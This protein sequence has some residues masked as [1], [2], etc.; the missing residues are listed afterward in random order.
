MKVLVTGGAGFIGSHTVVALYEAG[1]EPIIVDDFSNSDPQIIEGITAIIG[2]KPTVYQENCHSMDVLKSIFEKEQIEGVIHFAAFKA[3]GESMQKPLE[4]YD[5]NLGSLIVLLKCMLECGVKNLIFSSSCTVYGEPDA[6]PVTEQ[7]PVKPANS[8]YGNTQQIGEEIL[9][10]TVRSL[11][12]QSLKVLSLRYFNPVGAHPSA[13]IGELPRGVPNNLV[14]F[15][16]QAAAGIRGALTIFGDDYPTP[17]GTCIRDYIHVM[18]LA[19][20]HVAGFR[21]LMSHESPAIY[22]VV[23]VGT[24]SG[25]SVLELLQSFERINGL[26]V[27][28]KIGP[29]REGDVVAVYA[30]A[31]KAEKMLCW[32]ALRS[33]EDGLRDAWNWQK[34]TSKPE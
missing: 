14:P 1:F 9:S 29:R 4:Y 10:D 30:D 19:E 16:T 12:H 7:T 21:Y 28:Y 23:N 8:V 33:I 13:L 27:P 17:D 31:S 20:A 24:G 26:P 25:V 22:D 34:N 15:M 11:E 18:D 6:L 32:K 2:K 3:V 5:N